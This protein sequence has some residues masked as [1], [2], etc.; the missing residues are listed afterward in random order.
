MFAT[1]L[2]S[3]AGLWS[4]SDSLSLLPAAVELRSNSELSLHV[5]W[6]DELLERAASTNSLWY[7]LLNALMGRALTL[8]SSDFFPLESPAAVVTSPV[9]FLRQQRQ[10][11]ALWH[12]SALK[13][14][15]GER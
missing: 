5:E 15:E 2:R 4:N 6:S 11:G 13:H 14:V 10:V 9:L 1:L 7:E 3:D 12:D 8:L